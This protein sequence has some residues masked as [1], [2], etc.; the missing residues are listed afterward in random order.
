MK[1]L[2][3]LA[4]IL[5]PAFAIGQT[6]TPSVQPPPDF[7][8]LLQEGL[9]EEEANRNLDA[10]SAAYESLIQ[11]FEKDRQFAA[12]ALFR[13]AEVRTKQKD[14]DEAVTL[15][16]RILTEFANVDPF[17]R[18]S[19][20]RIAALGGKEPPGANTADISAEESQE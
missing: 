2:R 13:L 9:F 7:R 11:A 20:E 17:A 4:T 6:P 8:K 10:A 16:Q 1:A 12:T 5:L 18:L 3:L 14:N 15:Y 19:R